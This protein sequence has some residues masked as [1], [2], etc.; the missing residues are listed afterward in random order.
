[1]LLY[2][3]KTSSVGFNRLILSPDAKFAWSLSGSSTGWPRLG[4]VFDG[5][6]GAEFDVDCDA[7]VVTGVTRTGG[8]GGAVDTPSTT[9][10]RLGRTSGRH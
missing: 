5:C 1:M 9:R 2:T 10:H 4:V 6:V 3:R 7:V 8:G